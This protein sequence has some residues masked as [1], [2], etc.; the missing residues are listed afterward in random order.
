MRKDRFNEK[1]QHFFNIN[2]LATKQVDQEPPKLPHE[3]ESDKLKS[4]AQELD[5]SPIL[6]ESK[7]HR[8]KSENALR[9]TLNNLV[10]ALMKDD[11]LNKS[12]QVET[13]RTSQMGNSLVVIKKPS[14]RLIREEEIQKTRSSS[15]DDFYYRS[16]YWK[17]N[18]AKRYQHLQHKACEEELKECTF[19]PD[20][21]KT[22]VL[23]CPSNFFS[24]SK[25]HEISKP[26]PQ[27]TTK[28]NQKYYSDIH[29]TSNRMSMQSS[30]VASTFSTKQQSEVKPVLQE[31]G[32]SKAQ[33]FAKNYDSK[34]K[35]LHK[36]LH[37]MEF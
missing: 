10:M 16:I 6:A 19:H 21:T 15:F 11:D 24:F 4:V 32:K 22:F 9:E 34:V 26:A 2:A 20:T 14:E 1:F 8:S 31:Q 37:D 5:P 7:D 25:T 23:P 3:R 12:S 28:K 35:R 18:K 17:L 36:M 30:K 27:S 29:R 13:N 33:P